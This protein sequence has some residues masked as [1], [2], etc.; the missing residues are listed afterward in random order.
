[1]SGGGARA[2]Q[3]LNVYSNDYRIC[4]AQKFIGEKTNEVPAAQEALRIMDIKGTIITAD[5][6][7]CQK[8][9]AAVI[10]DG[11]EDY[12][13]ALKGNQPL[14]YNEVRGYFDDRCRETLRKK[15]GCYKKTAEAEHG[16]AVAREYYI[17]EDTGWYSEK[18]E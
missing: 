4:L 3:T 8:D 2:L 16:A 14:F 1:M 12:A 15:E 6:M 17:T 11:K 9:T 10:M 13:L 7:N 5:A 18:N